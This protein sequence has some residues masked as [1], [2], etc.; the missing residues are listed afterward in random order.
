MCLNRMRR[1][2]DYDNHS[3]SAPKE[4]IYVFLLFRLASS[5]RVHSRGTG[6]QRY[7]LMKFI[8]IVLNGIFRH[9]SPLYLPPE[10]PWGESY[11]SNRA[12]R[13]SLGCRSTTQRSVPKVHLICTAFVTC[14]HTMIWRPNVN[15]AFSDTDDM[16]KIELL[17][18][19][20]APISCQSNY[21]RLFIYADCIKIV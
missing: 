16:L 6:K 9:C 14:L 7:V 1:N 20:T 5:A 11:V 8:M 17:H 4:C 21:R 15:T 12:F 3:L 2:S 13:Q 10:S 18:I 19:T